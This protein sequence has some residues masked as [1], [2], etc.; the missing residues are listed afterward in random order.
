MQQIYVL[1]CKMESV[2]ARAWRKL[3]QP[4]VYFTVEPILLIFMF[5]SFLSYSV[6]Q[7]LVHRMVC[8]QTLNCSDDGAGEVGNG[9]SDQECFV[10]SDVQQ[11]VQS[12]SSHW[13]LYINLASGLPSIFL[14]MLYGSLSDLLGRK[15]FIALP[16]IGSIV[17]TAVIL[18]VVYLEDTLPIAFFLLGAFASGL[19]GNFSVL[20]FGVYSYASDIS[21]RSKRTV[22]IGVLESMTYLGATLS[23]LIGGVWIQSGKFGPPFW[24]ILCCQLAVIFYIVVFLPESLGSRTSSARSDGI[25]IQQKNKYKRRQSCTQLL[26]SIP[27]NLFNFGKMVLGS[28]RLLVLMLTFFVVEINFLGITDIVILYA[29]G[30]PLCWSSAWIGYF[31]ALKLFLNGLAALILLPVLVYVRV[32]DTVIILAG[33]AAGAASLVVM[34]VAVKTW[35]MFIGMLLASHPAVPTFFAYSTAFSSCK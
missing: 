12:R 26:K 24:C 4:R 9:T 3:H 6:F 17:N 15:T 27:Y 10:M 29:I 30:E 21:V 23:L 31:L 22:Q 13:L 19:F 25:N 35:I 1:R 8:H 32:P 11:T 5:A 16:P 34:G 7:Q 33:L 2:A 20:N 28:W 14:S 18:L